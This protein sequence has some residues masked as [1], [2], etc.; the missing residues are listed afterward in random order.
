MPAVINFSLSDDIIDVRDLIARVEELENLEPADETEKWN[1]CDEFSAL[2]DIL[3]EL[4]GN[5]G[6]EQWRGDWYP[7]TLIRDDYFTTYAQELA[8]DIGA[9]PA[10]VQW[11]MTCIDW[12]MA[13]RDLKMDYTSVEINGSTYWYR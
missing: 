2:T 13:A 11:P 9:V 10:N 6:D 8:D 7:I 12:D 3:E 4:A 1:N 5:G